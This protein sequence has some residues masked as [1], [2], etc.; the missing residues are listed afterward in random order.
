MTEIT[1]P[2]GAPGVPE[3]T[4]EQRT[5]VTL[6]PEVTEEQ[7]TSPRISARDFFIYLGPALIISLAFLDPGC[8]ATDIA[9]GAGFNYNLIWSLVMASMFAILLQYLSGKLGIATGNSVSQLVRT[10]LKTKSRIIPYWLGAELAIA[11]TD[12]SEYM[13]TVIALNLLF[14]IPLFYAS[15]LAAADV[16][17]LLVL[18]NGRFRII[19]Y[20][21]MFFVSIIS[22]GF[23]YELAVVGFNPAQVVI[24]TFTPTI[25][26]DSILIIVGIIGATV[27]PHTLWLHSGLTA[28][29]KKRWGIKDS[30]ELPK[31]KMLKLHT[32]ETLLIL[33][34]AMIV[35]V[36]VLVAAAAAFYP[37]YNIQQFSDAYNVLKPLFG[38]LAATV[39][40]IGILA[41]GISASTCG[42]L[43]GQEVM[44]SLL[45]IKV[46]RYLR[47][48]VT[49]GINVFP[50]TILLLLGLSPFAI[51]V[52]TQVVLSLM[53]PL[54]MI[55]I[56]WYTTRSKLMGSFVNS[57]TTSIIAVA[58]AVTL[59]ILNVVLI[60]TYF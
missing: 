26:Q 41:S 17:I 24:H 12:L 50:V 56:V 30:D 57:R 10:S 2:P 19:E 4:E 33:V 25:S 21:F 5:E 11:V 44:T 60:S 47:R 36:S 16:L 32:R 58:V 20:A 7:R 53:I 34:G 52:Y 46:N 31:K 1:G 15:F 23:L 22:I 45:G 37:Q 6:V 49:R 48:I 38:P 29:K 35:N 18:S 27:M 40:A 42:T 14:G 43:A 13:G 3:I 51:L 9:A 59:I 54:P 28:E 39:F 8:L 55:P